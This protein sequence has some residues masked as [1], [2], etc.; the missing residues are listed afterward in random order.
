MHVISDDAR[1]V[2]PILSSLRDD[3]ALGAMLSC[4]APALILRDQ[5]VKTLLNTGQGRMLP[6]AC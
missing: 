6:A 2:A 4:F 3:S 5:A 1:A